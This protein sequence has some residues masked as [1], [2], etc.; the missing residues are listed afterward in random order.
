MHFLTRHFQNTYV[1][2]IDPLRSQSYVSTDFGEAAARRIGD[3]NNP[4]PT[5][6][7]PEIDRR[8]GCARDSSAR[9]EDQANAEARAKGLDKV[10]SGE[11]WGT[12]SSGERLLEIGGWDGETGIGVL[13]DQGFA[14]GVGDVEGIEAELES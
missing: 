6:R 10:A 5:K 8:P 1:N 13:V 12:G 14:P 11:V 7:A 9:S 4:V 3:A 2:A